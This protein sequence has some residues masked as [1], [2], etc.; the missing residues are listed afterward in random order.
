MQRSYGWKKDLK[1]LR[2]FVFK[3]I[4]PAEG[5]PTSVDL[6][7]LCP[8][9]L[10]QK[11]LGSCTA[12]ALANAHLFAQIKETGGHDALPS[13]LFIYYKERELEGTIPEDCGAQI[14]DGAKVLASV[15][16]PPEAD[17]PYDIDKFAVAPPQVAIA[18]ASSHKTLQY[19]SVN[20]TEN[21]IKAA[22]ASGFPIVFGITLFQTFESDEVAKTGLVPM[23][24]A[25]EPCLGGHAILMVGYDDTKRL[26]TIMNSWGPTWGDKGF[27]YLPY[28]Y[29]LRSD[30]AQDFWVISQVHEV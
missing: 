30:L 11:S 5:L 3:A 10:D 9:V 8:P 22:L 27:F 6:R 7:H 12:H 28:E 1:D 23:P 13:R 25:N 26:F 2:D 19:H 24:V 4:A 20:Q 18:D 14:R 17:W 21:D 15:G 29:V 16:A